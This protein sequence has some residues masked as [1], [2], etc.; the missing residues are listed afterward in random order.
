MNITDLLA[1]LEELQALQ[2]L[3]KRPNIVKLLETEIVKMT[4]IMQSAK[5]QLEKT[6][7]KKEQEQEE[8]KEK[9]DIVYG[10]DGKPLLFTQLNGY[11]WDQ[12]HDALKIYITK[13]LDG[14]GKHD[15]EQIQCDFEEDSADLKI[16]NFNK[17]HLRLRLTPLTYKIKPQASK[18]QVK[19]NSITITMKKDDEGR[20]WINLLNQEANPFKAKRSVPL[21]DDGEPSMFAQMKDMYDKGDEE[22]R[23][24][25]AAAWQKA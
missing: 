13:D 9:K 14:I 22:Y 2:K 21:G 3:A 6:L 7:E 25:I 23:K 19:S 12:K 17:R 8:E 16:T 11:G 18:I 15:K 5:Q 1:D 10:P 20:H 4:P 24:T